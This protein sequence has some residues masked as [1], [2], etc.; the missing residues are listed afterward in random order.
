M[1]AK[2]WFPGETLVITVDNSKATAP[3]LVGVFSVYMCYSITRWCWVILDHWG[4]S[5]LS[6]VLVS[7]RR[8][9]SLS[10]IR[11][12]SNGV[13]L[14]TDLVFSEPNVRLTDDDGSGLI[15]TPPMIWSSRMQRLKRFRRRQ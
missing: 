13:L 6:H 8:D 1:C 11:P 2:S 5:N 10:A 4:S 14:T 12:W 9:R 7:A 3:G 15:S